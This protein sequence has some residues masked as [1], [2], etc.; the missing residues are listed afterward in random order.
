MTHFQNPF[1]DIAWNRVDF[2]GFGIQLGQGHSFIDNFEL[3]SK[4]DEL[5]A[6]GCGQEADGR[7]VIN[8]PS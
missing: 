3:E 7:T 5:S 8:L 2:L 6:G 1:E 4:G